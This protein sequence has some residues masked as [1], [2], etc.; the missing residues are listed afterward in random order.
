[1]PNSSKM[2]PRRKSGFARRSCAQC[3]ADK[4]KCQP[5]PGGTECERCAELGRSC[6]FAVAARAPAAPPADATTIT[7][8]GSLTDGPSA[9]PGLAAAAAAFVAG[10]TSPPVLHRTTLAAPGPTLLLAMAS[11]GASDLDE[12]RFFAGAALERTLAGLVDPLETAQC[13]VLLLHFFVFRTM[14]AAVAPLLVTGR[15]A[16]A[17]LCLDASGAFS[18]EVRE[19]STPDVWIRADSALR[20]WC[21]F[22]AFDSGAASYFGDDALFDAAICPVPLPAHEDYFFSPDP[23]AAFVA[24]CATGAFGPGRFADFSACVQ[25]AALEAGSAAIRQIVGA[26]FARRASCLAVCSVQA[27]V[28]SVRSKLRGFAIDR[29]VNPLAIMGKDREQCTPDERT[30]WDAL[31]ALH[32]LVGIFVDAMPEAVGGPLLAGDPLPLFSNPCFPNKACAHSFF[33]MAFAV[34]ATWL[35][36]AADPLETPASPLPS[37]ALFGS[38]AF[39]R[40]LDRVQT[41]SDLLEHLGDADL[42]QLHPV[43]SVHAMRVGMFSVALFRVVRDDLSS[44]WVAARLR[45]NVEFIARALGAVGLGRAPLVAKVAA[46]FARAAREAGALDEGFAGPEVTDAELGEV[47]VEFAR[48][49]IA[50]RESPVAALSEG[51]IQLDRGVSTWLPS[52]ENWTRRAISGKL[53]K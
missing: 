3:F 40:I 32:E 21:V 42:A 38:P 18:R 30:Y 36:A 17:T 51:M 41:M 50:E 33:G 49:G 47:H 31:D 2:P 12:A 27:F 43:L 22:N 37:D 6:E 52:L 26:V 7:P 13:V 9:V 28:R 39:V 24:L 20:C 48:L 16:L 53:D 23:R 8:P 5:R 10:G 35:E 45:R 1:M 34:M 14:S 44:E 25:M 15:A 4:K 46:D 19:P 11:L 29:R